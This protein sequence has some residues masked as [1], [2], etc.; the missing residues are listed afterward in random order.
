MDCL[1]HRNFVGDANGRFC[2]R[3][4]NYAP[5]LVSHHRQRRQQSA[6]HR[7]TSGGHGRSGQRP[8]LQQRRYHPRTKWSADRL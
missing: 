2:P 8:R 1:H 6:R 5:A 7:T 4:A 3:A